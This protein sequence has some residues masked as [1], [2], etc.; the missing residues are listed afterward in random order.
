MRLMTSSE[1]T[2][3]ERRRLMRS[4]TRS[5]MLSSNRLM[6]S[7]RADHQSEIASTSLKST[8]KKHRF[9]LLSLPE[10]LVEPPTKIMAHLCILMLEELYTIMSHGQTLPIQVNSHR[11]EDDSTTLEKKLNRTGEAMAPAL[12][13][14][15]LLTNASEQM[16]KI[17]ECGNQ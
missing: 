11:Q 6:L 14:T 1:E 5:T 3:T 7:T 9:H 4:D 10:C 2:W 13:M 12:Q 8:F 16:I 17:S 15:N